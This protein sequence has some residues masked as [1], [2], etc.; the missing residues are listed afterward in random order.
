MSQTLNALVE[1]ARSLVSLP[2]ALQV[3][4]T[5]R[6]NEWLLS[7][8]GRD[9]GVLSE[10]TYDDMFWSWWRVT[11]LHPLFVP[12]LLDPT[13]W[14]GVRFRVRHRQSGREVSTFSALGAPTPIEDE[15]GLR[16]LLRSFSPRD[17]EP[18]RP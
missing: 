3:R 14:S 8:D 5:E 10:P 18:R 11:P 4:W 1:L 16:V 6:S 13:V 12:R 9:L 17:E 2:R 15:R 7:L